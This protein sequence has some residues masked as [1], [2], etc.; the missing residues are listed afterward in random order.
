M[1]SDTVNDE[2]SKDLIAT[3]AR[4]SRSVTI[5][6]TEIEI[7]AIV[8]TIQSAEIAIPELGF[9]GGFIKATAKK[10][11]NS[12]KPESL[13]FLQLSEGWESEGVKSDD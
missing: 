5:T 1:S 7:F 8:S 2:Y 9:T 11:Q 10:M 13:L 12:L 6:L 3:H 4:N